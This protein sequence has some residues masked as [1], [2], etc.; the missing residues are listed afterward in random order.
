MATHSVDA[1]T[2]ALTTDAVQAKP[3]QSTGEV[4]GRVPASWLDILGTNDP[5]ERAELALR[6]WGPRIRQLVPEFF[7]NLQQKTEDVI[8][9]TLT[10]DGATTPILVYLCGRTNTGFPILWFGP[11]P[12]DTASNNLPP[13]LEPLASFFTETHSGFTA[14]DWVS[15]GIISPEWYDDLRSQSR[16]QDSEDV[17]LDDGR[18]INTR[19]L[20]V[21]AKYSGALFLCLSLETGEGVLEYEGNF[22]T[23]GPYFP[24]LDRLMTQAWDLQ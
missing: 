1:A 4:R 10:L 9:F 19:D 16:I 12:A 13:T 7:R 14:E 22:D 17:V 20:L 5:D 6:L 2:Y 24:H 23:A 8:L 15:N 3:V 21:T 11:S 18:T